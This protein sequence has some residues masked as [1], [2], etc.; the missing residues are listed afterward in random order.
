MSCNIDKIYDMLSWDNDLEIQTQ[1]IAEAKKMRS[2]SG[3]ILP[4]LGR[5]NSKAV[6]ENCAKVLEG[7]SNR[8]L[9]PYQ[10]E[11]FRWLQDLNWP[12]ATI[13]YDRLLQIPYSEIETALDVCLRSAK[14]TNDWAW[15]R[16]LLAFKKDKLDKGEI[17]E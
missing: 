3:F 11:L 4:I 5:K 8:E 10:Q 7:K 1:G 12:G 16:A 6:W 13:I 17:M 9:E 15:E 2:L 14:E